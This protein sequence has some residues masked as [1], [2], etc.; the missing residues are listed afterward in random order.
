MLGYLCKTGYLDLIYSKD[1]LEQDLV[2]VVDVAR[3]Y[4]INKTLVLNHLSQNSGF[5][6]FLGRKYN[7]TY[8]MPCVS[9]SPGGG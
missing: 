9:V 1:T 3:K 5:G 8:E 4:Y 7:M 6:M 2:E